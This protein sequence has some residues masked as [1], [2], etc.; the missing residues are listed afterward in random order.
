MSWDIWV[1]PKDEPA[2][3]ASDILIAR[4]LNDEAVKHL[5]AGGKVLL[6]PSPQTIRNDEKHPD[7]DGLFEHLLEYGLDELAGP[8]HAGHPVRPGTPGPAAIPHGVS[9]ELAVA[10]ADPRGGAVSFSRST[11]ISSP[12]SRS[13]MTG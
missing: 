12:S 6:L 7:P 5:D 2:E 11:A 9:F 4:E 10:G 8:A 13:S 3:P 1:Y